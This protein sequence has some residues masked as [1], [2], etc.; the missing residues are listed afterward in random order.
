MNPFIS[1]LAR[2]LG[3]VARIGG[4]RQQIAPY[5]VVAN[6]ERRVTSVHLELRR[7]R[8]WYPILHLQTTW[9][10]SRTIFLGSPCQGGNATHYNHACYVFSLY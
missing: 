5:H 2:G 9:Y 3:A 6:A 10:L 8:W 4:D 1:C 7:Y